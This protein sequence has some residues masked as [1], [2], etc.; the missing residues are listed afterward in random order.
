MIIWI[1]KTHTFIIIFFFSICLCIITHNTFLCSLVFHQLSAKDL[2]S[3]ICVPIC[4]KN[5]FGYWKCNLNLFL[6]SLG[7]YISNIVYELLDVSDGPK[8]WCT[9]IWWFWC[10]IKKCGL[11]LFYNL[12]ITNLIT[13]KN[14]LL[15]GIWVRY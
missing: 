6:H 2:C 10:R 1:L 4:F 8:P 9:N 12:I 15:I 11:I 5:R 3:A 14:A 7:L 13:D